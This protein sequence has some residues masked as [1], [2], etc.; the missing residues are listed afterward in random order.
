MSHVLILAVGVAAGALVQSR[1]HAHRT[2]EA[3]WDETKARAFAEAGD[4][5]FDDLFRAGRLLK[6]RDVT[7]RRLRRP[8]RRYIPRGTA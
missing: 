2:E 1:V 7:I 8:P 3:A 6:A 5:L 4:R